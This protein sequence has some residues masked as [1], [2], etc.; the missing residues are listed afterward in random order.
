MKKIFAILVP[1][2]A[3]LLFS[4][5]PSKKTATS[6]STASLEN[7]YW[8]LSEAGN[9]PVITPVNAKEVHIK[10]VAE[11]KRFQ[12]FAGCNTLGGSYGTSGTNNI[13]ILAISTKMACKDRMELENFLTEALSKTN[14][15]K[16]N[17]E[18]LFLYHDNILLAKFESVYF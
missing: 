17:G 15:Y 3:A 18:K 5:S 10:F 2:L 4:C 6:K 12:G 13:Q 8:K 16:I 1:V 9:K 7:T 11:G 14:T